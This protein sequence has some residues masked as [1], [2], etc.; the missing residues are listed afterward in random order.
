MSANRSISRLVAEAAERESAPISANMQPLTTEVDGIEW[1][2]YL[3][4]GQLRWWAN[5]EP[6]P[7]G[8]RQLY[9]RVED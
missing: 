3:K 4:G 1:L 7:E 9:V 2:G 8:A 5:T 6:L